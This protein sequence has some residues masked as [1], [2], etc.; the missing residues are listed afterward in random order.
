MMFL[1][2]KPA[3]RKV[4]MIGL[5]CADPH[6]VFQLWRTKLPNLNRLMTAGAY[7]RLRSILPPITIPAWMCMMTSRDPG[8]LGI[9]GFRNRADYSYDNLQIVSSRNISDP[10]LWDILG[11]RDKYTIAIGMPPTFPVRPMHG[12][13][14]S[15]FLTPSADEVF[16]HPPELK[17]EV[18]D[19][20]GRY[21]FDV[22]AHRTH[23]KESLLRQA[24]A[25][26]G[27]RFALAKHLLASRP[28][29]FFCMVEIGIDRIHHAFWHFMDPDHVLHPGTNPYQHAIEAYYRYVDGLLGELLEL[30][31]PDTWILVTSDH[32]AKRMDGGIAINEWLVREGYLVLQDYPVEPTRFADCHVDWK[33]TRVWAEGGYYGRIF[34]NIR[35]REPEGCVPQEDYDGL[36]RELKGKLES[37]GDEEGRPLR[38]TVVRPREIYHNTYNVPPD[39]MVF[40]GDLYWRALGSL[41]S[42]SIHHKENDIGPDGANHDWDGIFILATGKNLQKGKTIDRNL[43]TSGILD[44]A[45]TILQAYG[46]D[47]LPSMRGAGIQLPSM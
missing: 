38:T 33:R 41:G 16:T 29:D 3:P 35:G 26:T 25:M 1:R 46:L 36:C 22:D 21:I 4:M 43:G 45:P 12:D 30:A 31:T 10:T 5:D 18:E 15:G 24:Y 19:V 8:D 2:G 37:L 40:F 7:G 32:G 39:L 28:W 20:V 44:V 6:L 23:D 11:A 47:P 14:V 13:L 42:R 17:S 9:Y 27:K 34:L